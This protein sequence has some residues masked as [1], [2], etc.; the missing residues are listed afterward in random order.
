MCANSI[1][2]AEVRDKPRLVELTSMMIGGEDRP[3]ASRALGEEFIDRKE[4][5]V[6]VVEPVPDAVGGFGMLKFPA[7]EGVDD[8][9]ELVF[10][11]WTSR[12]GGK[13][14]EPC[15]SGRSRSTRWKTASGNY[16]VRQTAEFAR[17]VLLDHDGVSIRSQDAEVR[18]RHG[19]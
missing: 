5:S 11:G 6:F 8:V 3:A 18:L 1:R 9:G 10:L 4:F 13:G 7:F 12:I 17:S 14:W 2:S 15:S 19:G 16:T